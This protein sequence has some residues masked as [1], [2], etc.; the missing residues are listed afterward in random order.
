MDRITFNVRRAGV[1]Y[2]ACAAKVLR[3]WSFTHSRVDIFVLHAR[4]VAM[5]GVVFQSD[6]RARLGIAPCT[7]TI[8]MQRLERRGFIERRPA[9]HD[10]RLIV[11][12]IT[13][14]GR[15]VFADLT[16]HIGA[17][18]F[19]PHVDTQLMFTGKVRVPVALKRAR[20]LA[21]ID[22]VRNLFGDMSRAPYPP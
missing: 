11:V 16:A 19:T 8:M 12:S 21:A 20:C 14:L 1:A 4:I 6:I 7:M 22:V 3:R 10:R 18:L 5:H 2:A 9:E 15:R 13:E 17:D